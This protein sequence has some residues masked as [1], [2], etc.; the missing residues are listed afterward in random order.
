MLLMDIIVR[1]YLPKLERN[2]DFMTMNGIIHDGF[3]VPL[4]NTDMLVISRSLIF[5]NNSQIH[6]KSNSIR[7][8]KCHN[9]NV[10]SV[11]NYQR[12]K[13]ISVSRGTYGQIFRFLTWVS[14]QI[15]IYIKFK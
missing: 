1:G 11:K 8:D 9:L 3:S 15:S 4:K 12:D 14:I 7:N 6:Q 10:L 5:G 13:I 2:N